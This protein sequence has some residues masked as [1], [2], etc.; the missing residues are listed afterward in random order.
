MKRCGEDKRGKWGSVRAGMGKRQAK[1]E[2]EKKH[3]KKGQK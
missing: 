2:V 1:S 3:L